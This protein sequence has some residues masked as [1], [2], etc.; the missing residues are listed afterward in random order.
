MYYYQVIDVEGERLAVYQ[1]DASRQ[2][3]YHYVMDY[4]ELEQF[5]RLHK[6]VMPL[7]RL[8]ELPFDLRVKHIELSMD[9]LS[10]AQ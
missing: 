1:R 6:I 5:C 10:V 4:D 3:S 2:S 7:T 9:T 8:F